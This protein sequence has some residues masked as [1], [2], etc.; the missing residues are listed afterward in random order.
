MPEREEEKLNKKGYK[1]VAGIDEA[2]RGPLAGPVVASVVLITDW[3]LPEELL[4]GIK[5]SKKL[6]EK[7]REYLFEI[8]TITKQIK[9]G[10]GIV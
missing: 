5:D 4:L 2:G 1:F 3:N 10:I 9:W 8:I 7:K 6:S